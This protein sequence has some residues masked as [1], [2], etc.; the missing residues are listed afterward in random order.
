MFASIALCLLAGLAVYVRAP[1]ARP[2]AR[3]VAAEA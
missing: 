2:S 3:R 1:D